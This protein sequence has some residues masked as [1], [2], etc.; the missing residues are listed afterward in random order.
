MK[1]FKFLI[2]LVF[3]LSSVNLSLSEE[4][5]QWVRVKFLGTGIG[6]GG[7]Q[8]KWDSDLDEDLMFLKELEKA[9][10]VKPE[11]KVNFATLE[12]LDEI[13]KFPILFMHAETEVK[14]TDI[15]IKNMKEYCLRGGFIW[16]DDCVL[17]NTRGDFFFQFFKKTVETQIFPGRKM[18]I[19]QNDHEIFCCHFDM[20]KGLPYCQGSPNG[21][22]GLHDDKGRL[23]ILAMS[24]DLHCGWNNIDK[25]FGEK[26]TKESYQMSINIVIYALTH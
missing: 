19:L 12:K 26:K 14:F 1:H 10:T 22:W 8:D 16:A 25:Y 17:A 21:A 7:N 6:V 13:T 3:I 11:M 9:S 4:K 2:V 5:F 23:M 20:P 15:E 24:T 18:E